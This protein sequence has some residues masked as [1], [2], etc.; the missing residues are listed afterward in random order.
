MG[1]GIPGGYA[2]KGTPGKDTDTCFC[3]QHHT[4]TLTR[5]THTR[6]CGFDTCPH[7]FYIVYIYILL[8]YFIISFYFI[9][10]YLFINTSESQQLEQW[11]PR[12]S[13]NSYH[14][15]NTATDT[16]G[17]AGV[18]WGLD[19]GCWW[20]GLEKGGRW[21]GDGQGSRRDTSRALVCFFFYLKPFLNLLIHIFYISYRLQYMETTHRPHPR[22]KHE[23]VGLFLTLR[24]DDMQNNPQTPPSLQTRVG[25][26]VSYLTTWRGMQIRPTDPTLAT[27]VSRRGRF[28]II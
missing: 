19:E 3:T 24:H 13:K 16:T 5:Q 6:R 7:S 4:R 9:F 11:P 14:T 26:V 12:R 8:F 25:G 1:M 18:G 27:N 23:S 10:V 28:F 21:A 22:Y 2:G 20:I 17:I 15:T